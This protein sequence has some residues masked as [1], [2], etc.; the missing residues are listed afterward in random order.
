MIM[1]EELTQTVSVMFQDERD[2]GIESDD[3][4]LLKMYYYL[5]TISKR[6]NVFKNIESLTEEHTTPTEN[7]KEMENKPNKNGEAKPDR[8]TATAD[9]DEH[10]FDDPDDETEKQLRELK[11]DSAI[12]EAERRARQRII[13]QNIERDDAREFEAGIPEEIEL[14]RL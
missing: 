9:Y 7:G 13:E 11:D 1:N 8:E 2:N 14:V 5:A 6:E 4:T 10:I 12:R 3:N